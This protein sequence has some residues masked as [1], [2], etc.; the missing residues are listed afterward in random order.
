MTPLQNQQL[1]EHM[2]VSRGS[3]LRRAAKHLDSGMH[4]RLDN[5]YGAK[6]MFQN[7]LFWGSRQ[8]S[9]GESRHDSTL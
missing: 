8:G 7:P 4:S 3:A 5:C 2:Q 6:Q 9:G 1:R